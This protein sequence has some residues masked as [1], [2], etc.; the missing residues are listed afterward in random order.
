MRSRELKKKTILDQ[1]YTMNEGRA[2]GKDLSTLKKQL[3]SQP[4]CG[5]AVE[6]VCQHRPGRG[7]APD[8][9]ILASA[10]ILRLLCQGL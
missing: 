2:V 9:G 6:G 1:G 3:V 8:Q 5:P 4:S 10:H 7:L